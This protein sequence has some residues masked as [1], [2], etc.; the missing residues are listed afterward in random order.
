MTAHEMKEAFMARAR[1]E[2]IGILYAGPWAAMTPEDEARC[3]D[4][5]RARYE[6]QQQPPGEDGHKKPLIQWF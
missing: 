4:A 1:H 5:I 6:R 3:A 2:G